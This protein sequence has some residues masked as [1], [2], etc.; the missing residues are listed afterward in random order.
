[1]LNLFYT[2]KV[3][4]N[5]NVFLYELKSVYDVEP[6]LMNTENI[7]LIYFYYCHIEM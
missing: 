5:H 7:F 6:L 3:I 4:N 1:M 2:I